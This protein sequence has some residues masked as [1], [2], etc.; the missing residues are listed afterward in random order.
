MSIES[1]TTQP[2]KLQQKPSS[3]NKSEFSSQTGMLNNLGL[4][5]EPDIKKMGSLE[6]TKESAETKPGDMKKIENKKLPLTVRHQSSGCTLQAFSS[7][8]SFKNNSNE[9]VS[10]AATSVQSVYQ[11]VLQNKKGLNNQIKR[12]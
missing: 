2:L 5:E 11:A 9:K 10:D 7:K 4:E 1:I 6:K 8:K 3:S 12:V